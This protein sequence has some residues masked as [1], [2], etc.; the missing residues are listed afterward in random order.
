MNVFKVKVRHGLER[1]YDKQWWTGEI[2]VYDIK[3][4]LHDNDINF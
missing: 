2:K 3:Y 1:K 4:G